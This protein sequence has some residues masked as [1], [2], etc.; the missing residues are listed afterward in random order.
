[1]TEL[2]PCPFCGSTDVELRAGAV[3]HGAVHCNACTADVVFDAMRM[4]EQGD[5]D[6]ETAVTDSWNGRADNG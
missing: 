4:I 1:M 3:F 5:Y 6:C 2:K